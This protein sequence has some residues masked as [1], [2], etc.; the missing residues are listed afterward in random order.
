MIIDMHCHVMDDASERAKVDRLLELAGRFGIERLITSMGKDLVVQPTADQ[1]REAND[2]V[3]GLVKGWPGR[4]HGYCYLNPRL[5]RSACLDELQRCLDAGLIAIKLWVACACDAPEVFPIVE[6]AIDLDIPIL[7][8]SWLKTEGNMPE[9][10]E[11]RQIAD[12]AAR[13]PQ[14]RLIM[15]HCGGAWEYGVKAVRRSPN[16]FADISGANPTQGLLEMALR[17]LGAER[18]LFGSDAPLRSFA[19]QIAKVDGV[20]VSQKMRQMILCGNAM[21]LFKLNGR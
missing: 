8:H 4:I 19:S 11:P 7:Q 5:G 10:T 3:I 20:K 15:A 12:L 17:D 14:A 9:E 13:Y 16:V 6:R 21:K 1:I 2:H 18:I